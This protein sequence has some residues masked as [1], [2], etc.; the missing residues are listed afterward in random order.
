LQQQAHHP[1]IEAFG[2]ELTLTRISLDSRKLWPR[3]DRFM[4][5]SPIAASEN[6]CCKLLGD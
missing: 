4:R 1:R 6:L 3:I 2:C 5:S